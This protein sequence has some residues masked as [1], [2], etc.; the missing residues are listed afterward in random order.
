MKFFVNRNPVTLSDKHFLAQGGEGALYVDNGT[1]YKIWLDPQKATPPAK[2][3]EL[4]VLSRPNIVRPLEFIEDANY[5]PVGLTFTEVPNATPLTK[6]CSTAYQQR[7]KFAVTDLFGFLSQMEETTDFI[8]SHGCLIVDGNEFNYLLSV[9]RIFFID[10]D[11]YQTPSFPATAIMASQTS[12]IRDYHAA[13]FSK[14]TDWFSFAVVACKLLL[15]IHPYQGTHSQYGKDIV[16]RMKANVS[17]FNGNVRLPSTVRD[18]TALPKAYV[19]W[20]ERVFEKGERSHPPIAKDFTTFAARIAAPTIQPVSGA[21]FVIVLLGDAPETA[22]DLGTIP[23]TGGYF[24]K[25]GAQFQFVKEVRTQKG[26]TDTVVKAWDILPNASSLYQG[27]LI[28]DVLG[29]PYFYVPE[30]EACH[31]F[32]MRDLKGYRILDAKRERDFALV[33]IVTLTTGEYSLRLYHLDFAQDAASL[34]HSKDADVDVNMAVLDTGIGAMI[35]EDGE[36]VLFDRNRAQ[37]VRSPEIRATMRLVS[38]GHELGFIENAQLFSLTMAR[39][40]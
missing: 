30:G 40:K 11:S 2:V 26:V 31:I 35:V 25:R 32:P 38:R 36:M 20:M 1:V 12:N 21:T 7:E 37:S 9:K 24:A 27:M 8:H 15:G 13:Q 3:K 14:E 39:R 34:L 10:V 18:R 19:D 33:K 6:V 22:G 5:A 16:A 4:G 17:V 23:V 28:S 29:L